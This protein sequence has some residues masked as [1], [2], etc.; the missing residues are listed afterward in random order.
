MLG[1]VRMH[2][3][4]VHQAQPLRRI[5]CKPTSSQGDISASGRLQFSLPLQNAGTSGGCFG[6]GDMSSLMQRNG[7][8]GVG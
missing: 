1:T 7:K 2:K 4:I 3:P 6:L 5:A 8:S